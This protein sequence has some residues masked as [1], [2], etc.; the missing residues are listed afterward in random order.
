MAQPSYHTSLL[1]FTTA[2]FAN[3]NAVVSIIPILAGLNTIARPASGLSLLGFVAPPQPEAQKLI[4]SLLLMT[5]I[6][7][8]TMGLT[9]LALWSVGEYR[10]MGI[11]MLVNTSIAVVDGFVSRWQ[12]GGGEWGHWA[13]APVSL[14]LGA[15]LLG[16]I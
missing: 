10:S 3:A 12:T 11:A 6:R 8:A 9:S 2:T 7:T 16:W 15:G 14:V 13:A 1:G 5:G 4:R